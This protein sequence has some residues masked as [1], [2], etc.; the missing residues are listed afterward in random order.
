ME[1]TGD[2]LI[3]VIVKN[4]KITLLGVVD[5]EGDKTLAGIRA[6]DVPGSF[7]VENELAVEKSEQKVTKP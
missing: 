1:A 4:G 7:A 3:H 6:R 2:Y 5:T